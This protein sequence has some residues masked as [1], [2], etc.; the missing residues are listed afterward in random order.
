MALPRSRP[1]RI[2]VP[3]INVDSSLLALGVEPDGAMQVP[4][5]SK[6][7]TAGWYRYSPTPGQKGPAVV[8]GHV[9]SPRYGPGVFYRLGAVEAGDVV[10]VRRA[11]GIVAVFTV[12]KVV[13]FPKDDFPTDVVYGDLDHPGLRL[14][15]CGGDY[16]PSAGGYQ[17]NTVVFASLTGIRRPGRSHHDS[18]A[19]TVASRLEGGDVNVHTG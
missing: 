3:A 12:N 13:G 15:T 11:D 19:G 6:S 1:V 17:E 7:D 2:T 14:I 5:Y 9:D 8:V 16:E 10:R 18:A 4:S